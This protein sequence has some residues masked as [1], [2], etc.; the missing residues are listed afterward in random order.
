MGNH[1]TVKKSFTDACKPAADLHGQ[2]HT[3]C[4]DDC[5]DNTR[6]CERSVESQVDFHCLHPEGAYSKA[7]WVVD[8][9][10]H[11]FSEFVSRGSDN[12]SGYIDHAFGPPITQEELIR[13]V[14]KLQVGRVALELDA[15]LDP[16]ARIGM[17][18]HTI[19]DVFISVHLAHLDACANLGHL[20]AEERTRVLYSNE[21]RCFQVCSLLEQHGASFAGAQPW[22]HTH[23]NVRPPSSFHSVRG[24][25]SQASSPQRVGGSNPSEPAP[26]SVSAAGDH[27]SFVRD[28]WDHSAFPMNKIE[29]IPADFY[30]YKDISGGRVTAQ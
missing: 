8:D 10:K 7:G 3:K 6:K 4:V 1:P 25:A 2:H 11:N 26:A 17:D 16:N 13:S 12:F 27:E 5:T 14:E 21:E 29:L 28:P 19:L 18:G 22:A 20:S 30:S 15:G 23:R 9:H 24:S